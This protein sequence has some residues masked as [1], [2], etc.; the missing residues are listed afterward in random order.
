[1]EIHSKNQFA[2]Y[3]ALKML[4]FEPTKILDVGSNFG[5]W[6]LMMKELYPDAEYT[7]IEANKECLDKMRANGFTNVHQAVLGNENKKVTFHKCQTGCTE[8]NSVFKEQSVFPFSQEEVQMTRLD[9][10]L[11]NGD[12]HLVKIDTQ[13]A[14]KIILEGGANCIKNAAFIQLETQIQEYNKNAPFTLDIINYMDNIGFRLYDIIDFHY[15]S[16][17]LLIQ[18]DLLFGRKDLFLF[19][20]ERYS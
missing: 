20:L 8:G 17:N 2:R 19:N 15:N 5:D 12:Y 10:L 1:M 16:F 3:N 9:D 11:P 18:V 6:S 4:G 7:L 13:G 14:E